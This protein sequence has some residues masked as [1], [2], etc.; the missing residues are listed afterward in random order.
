MGSRRDLS[1]SDRF[2]PAGPVAGFPRVIGKRPTSAVDAD[3]IR[4]CGTSATCRAAFHLRAIP[5]CPVAQ[6]AMVALAARGTGW[7][8][9]EIPGPDAPG[10][11]LP[12]L[13]VRQ[14]GSPDRI[15]DKSIAMVEAVENLHPGRPLYPENRDERGAVRALM[16]LGRGL[17]IRLS[18]VTHAR[19][20]VEN[21]YAI[22]RLRQRLNLVEKTLADAPDIVARPLSNAGVVFGPTLWRIIFV[23][24][25]FETHLLS[26]LSRLSSW[27]HRLSEHPAMRNVLGTGGE[28]T[29][30][31]LLQGR[32]VPLV[33]KVDAE[34]WRR[35]YGA[36]GP[37]RGAG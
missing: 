15:F 28:K 23:D 4:Q 24:R 37:H 22:H 29:Y 17:Q 30:L 16:E 14:P 25:R 6:R 20:S 32:G 31:A 26:G 2:R 33:S 18:A 13:V 1:A 5:F 35:A 7:S 36:G 9:E 19:D 3:G 27:G 10:R 12:Q 34:L 8:M 21:D 11:G